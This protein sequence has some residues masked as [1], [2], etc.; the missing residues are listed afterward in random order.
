MQVQQGLPWCIHSLVLASWTGLIPGN[1][2]VMSCQWSPIT[3]LANLKT[4][5]HPTIKSNLN[6]IT[7]Q[8]CGSWQYAHGRRLTVVWVILLLANR[9]TGAFFFRLGLAWGDDCFVWLSSKL[10]TTSG[11]NVEIFS[12]TGIELLQWVGFCVLI[13]WWVASVDQCSKGRYEPGGS[14]AAACGLL[15]TLLCRAG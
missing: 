7:S 11:M 14:M 3:R 9:G 6:S 4:C 10:W 13:H 12:Q 5:Y 8:S 15:A 2:W 1:G